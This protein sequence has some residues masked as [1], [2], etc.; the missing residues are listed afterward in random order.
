MKTQC[1]SCET[2]QKIP[3]I[4]EGKDIKC[5]N[6]N[7]TFKAEKLS[8]AP[9]RIDITRKQ[10]PPVKVKISPASGPIRCAKCGSE[11][12]TANKKGF[13]GGK[14]VGGALL[15]G[16]LGILVG[17]HGSKKIIVTCLNCG[18]SWEPG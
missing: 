12:V 11:Q 1:P 13:S 15:V 9:V 17:I 14:A 2:V 16:P 10:E 6:C 18:N 8:K 7:K 4:Y 3:D 5:E